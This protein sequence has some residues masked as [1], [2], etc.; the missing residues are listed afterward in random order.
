[1]AFVNL[2][3][4][5]NI[6]R[7]RLTAVDMMLSRSMSYRF[8]I[9]PYLPGGSTVQCGE[10]CMVLASPVVLCLLIDLI[11]FITPPRLAE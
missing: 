10:I 9:V 11:I 1:M 7:E 8:G 6:T 2:L 3:Q 5:R 4:L